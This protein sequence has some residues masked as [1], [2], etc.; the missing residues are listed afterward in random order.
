MEDIPPFLIASHWRWT[1][2]ELAVLFECNV[3]A[4]ITP[5]GGHGDYVIGA[6]SLA[7]LLEGVKLHSDLR[8]H[9]GGGQLLQWLASRDGLTLI[10]LL[11][12]IQG[13][14]GA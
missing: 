13:V 9:D 1:L 4:D 10:P 6:C 8:V 12:T 2:G 14:V 3:L 5:T 11:R 7:K